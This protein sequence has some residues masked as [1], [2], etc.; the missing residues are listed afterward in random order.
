MIKLMQ[1]TGVKCLFTNK[2]NQWLKTF[3][4]MHKT[5]KNHHFCCWLK[6]KY[7]WLKMFY[8]SKNLN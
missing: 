2:L 4:Q 5:K 3:I 6:W 1:R 8:S 7:N